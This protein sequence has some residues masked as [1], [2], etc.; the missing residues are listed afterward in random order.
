TLQ[1]VCGAP[2]VFSGMKTPLA[3]PGITLPDGVKLRKAKIRGVVSNGMLCSAIEL[4]LGDE[5]DGIME[6]PADAPVGESLVDYLSL[7]D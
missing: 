6:L 2:N 3:K 4:G 1:I 7:P 5:S